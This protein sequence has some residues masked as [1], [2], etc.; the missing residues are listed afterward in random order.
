MLAPPIDNLLI[1]IEFVQFAIL[2]R[3]MQLLHVLFLTLRAAFLF[4]ILL[5]ILILI[6]TIFLPH[7]L[8][9]SWR[10]TLIV[11][12]FPSFLLVENAVG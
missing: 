3:T 1:N 9:L 6:L 11:E 8:L 5:I 4:G 2:V 7:F 10:H 12:D